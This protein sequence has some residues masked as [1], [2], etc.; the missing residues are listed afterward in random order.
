MS[1][2][3][4][5]QILT[6]N[7]FRTSQ[8]GNGKTPAQNAAAWAEYKKAHGITTKSKPK[9]AKVVVIEA[10]RTGPNL[11]I[12]EP[13]LPATVTETIVQESK[14]EDCSCTTDH[15]RLEK[16]ES[17]VHQLTKKFEAM[18]AGG[19]SSEAKPKVKRAPSAWNNYVAEH[20]KDDDLKDLPPQ[21]R[22]KVLSQRFR[23]SHVEAPAA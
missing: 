1:A 9:K 16:V 14:E 20:M 5:T 7:E 12:D 17:K 10:P 4:S 23:A 13:V 22:M 6:W 8:K 15:E 19:S 2:E 3:S 18:S 11:I 21:E